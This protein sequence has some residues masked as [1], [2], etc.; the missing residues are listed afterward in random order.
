MIPETISASD[1][2]KVLGLTRTSISRLAADGVIPRDGRTYPFPDAAVAYCEHMRSNKSKAG[3]PSDPVTDPYKAAKIAQAEAS[4]ALTDLKR[5]RAEGELLD[6]AEV[7]STWRAILTDVRAALLAV[8]SRVGTR[9]P[10]LTATDLEEIAAEIR[11][12]LEALSND[13]A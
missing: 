4:A 3:R 2:A 9:L 12:A 10:T 11:A 5:R 7:E 1:L 6:R 13:P 8:P